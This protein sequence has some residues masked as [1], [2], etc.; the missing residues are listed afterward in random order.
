M[1]P[2]QCFCPACVQHAAS[3]NVNNF[4]FP[5][6]NSRT[7]S[8]ALRATGLNT[9]SIPA[10]NN[11]REAL[12][13]S[14]IG[15]QQPPEPKFHKFMELLPELRRR[16]YEFALALDS[17]IRPQ[18]C[19]HSGGKIK[20]HDRNQD[21]HDAVTRRLGVTRVSRLIRA[22]SLPAFYEAN[23]F[24]GSNSDLSVYLWTGSLT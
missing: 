14:L 23:V 4:P 20:F 11:G 19:S 1:D 7:R 21:V 12:W 18:L 15:H 9:S 22:E 8:T 24:S 5:G 13:W 2:Q 16:I 17:P 3:L 10:S 6:V